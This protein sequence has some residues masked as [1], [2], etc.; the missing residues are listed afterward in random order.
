MI[1]SV[2]EGVKEVE[3]PTSAREMLHS[4]LEVALGAFSEDRD[5]YMNSVVDMIN[6]VF[7]T[8]RQQYAS[9][10]ET[11]EKIVEE[12]SEELQ[13]QNSVIDAAQ[14]HVAEQHAQ[15]KALTAK[16]AAVAEEFR[17]RRNAAEEIQRECDNAGAEI[18]RDGKAQEV[19]EAT[20]EECFRPLCSEGVPEGGADEANLKIKKLCEALVVA[21][22]D[23]SMV[24]ALPMALVKAI[25]SRGAFDVMC[26]QQVEQEVGNRASAFKARVDGAASATAAREKTLQEAKTLFERSKSQQLEL[27]QQLSIAQEEETARNIKVLEVKDVAKA[28]RKKSREA[29]NA[30]DS[31]SRTLNCFNSGPVKAFETL[32]ER[33]KPPAP[34]VEPEPVV[35]DEPE[36]VA[37][38]DAA[39]PAADEAMPEAVAAA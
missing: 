6:G 29:E 27:A 12:A 3:I 23:D 2:E 9:E 13:K 5:K 20:I 17:S 30:G 4:M 15:V 16:L 33:T 10:V 39:P 34:V 35:A 1:V 21:K 11:S 24:Q 37:A 7:T 8:S 28:I 32:R 36:E 19:L 38:E 25:S 14:N 18:E 31:W 26:I 22:F